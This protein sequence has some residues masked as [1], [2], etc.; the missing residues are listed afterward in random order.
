MEILHGMNII[1]ERGI[2]RERQWWWHQI[3]KCLQPLYRSLLVVQ[4]S[5]ESSLRELRSHATC[6]RTRLCVHN[7]PSTHHHL[8]HKFKVNFAPNIQSS[9]LC[10]TSRVLLGR[11]NLNFVRCNDLQSA[12]IWSQLGFVLLLSNR[13]NLTQYDK[14]SIWESCCVEVPQRKLKTFFH[15]SSDNKIS[16]STPNTQQPSTQDEEETFQWP[17]LCIKH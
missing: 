5:R 14:A 3:R 9:A 4:I 2:E 10:V 13:P 16:H 1:I 7:F 17:N 8:R 15:L 12:W 6:C 11:V